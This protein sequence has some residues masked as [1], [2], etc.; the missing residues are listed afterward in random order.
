MIIN[1]LTNKAKD[2]HELRS[3]ISELQSEA[4]TIEDEIKAHMTAQGAET[5][6]AGSFRLT[7]KSITS[8]RFDASAF[9]KAMPDLAEHFMTSTITRR[10][11]IA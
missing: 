3:M 4:E 8:L 6:T 11:T 1:E 9:K 5:I 7:W 2:L 10:F